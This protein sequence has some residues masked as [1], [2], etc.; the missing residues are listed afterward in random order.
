[1]DRAYLEQVRSTGLLTFTPRG[2]HC[3]IADVYID[4]MKGVD[5]AIVT[6]AHSDHARGG[7][8]HYLTHPITKQLMHSRIG[9]NLDIDT[10][11][12]G[13]STVINGVRFSF[14][15][16]GHIPGSM[17][18]RVE[19]KGE[20]WVATGDYKRQTDT[21]CDAFEPVKCHT[22]ITECTFGLPI[23]R[24]K[25]TAE[26]FE[27]MNTWWRDNAANG[28][29]SV[30]QAYS[31][32]KAQQI[33]K[34]VDHRIGPVLVHTSV[35]NMNAAL[36]EMGIDLPACELIT[37]DTPAER[38]RN[39]LVITP[40][41]ALQTQWSEK[42]Q[43]YVTA[44]ASGWMRLRSWRQRSKLDRGF[45]LSDHADWPALLQTI[46]ETGAEQ[47]IATHGYTKV[48]SEHLRSIGYDARADRP[49]RD[50]EHDDELAQVDTEGG[51]AASSASR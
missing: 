11:V 51:D 4:P 1:M 12:P 6:H 35:A 50:G 46:R 26:V 34:E 38:F 16:A 30:I 40:G 20:V 7:S 25:D 37:R 49:E 36:A 14:H 8:K 32:G 5:R 13:E 3:P 44:M 29:C 48:F 33:I 27:E 42:M 10:M 39:A 31:L 47:V 18:V 15:P 28:V 45:V 2:I 43:P 19:H 9:K 17:Q 41:S 21:L 24:W 23:Y 22:F